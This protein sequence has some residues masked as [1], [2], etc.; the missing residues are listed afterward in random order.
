MSRPAPAVTDRPRLSLLA[1]EDLELLLT[2]RHV[3]LAVLDLFGRGLVG[4]TTHTCLGQEYVPVSLR[5]L[6]AG[7]VVFSNHRGHGH[8][9]AAFPEPDGLLAEITGRVG[10]VSG[11]VGGSQHLGRDRFYSTGIQGAAVPAALGAAVHLARGGG[12]ARRGA[13]AVVYVGDG[14]WG[15]GVV[16][17]TLNLACLLAAPLI[18]VV[19][20]NAIAQTTPLMRHMAGT[21]AGRAAAFGARYRAVH[22]NDVNRIRADLA[23]PVALA[24]NGGGPLVV[25]FFTDRLGPHSKGDDTRSPAA[26]ARLRERD[27]YRVYAHEHPH[28]FQR[29]DGRCRK[30]VTDIVA[31]VLARPLVGRVQQ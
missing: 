3:E 27:W 25:E 14:T 13:L 22:G 29:W 19:E 17:E 4:G 18:L 15:Q 10:A 12:A 2:I 23:A 5:P 31:E 1:D 30:R 6:L 7:A 24:G 20:N 28:Q 21:V 26:V 8:Y 11:G 9:L 16:Y